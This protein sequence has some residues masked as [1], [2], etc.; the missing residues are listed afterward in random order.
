[1]LY[2]LQQRVVFLF[3]FRFSTSNTHR[4]LLL[5]WPARGLLLGRRTTGR[6]IALVRHITFIKA[7]NNPYCQDNKTKMPLVLCWYA[8]CNPLRD[9]GSSCCKYKT[10]SLQVYSSWSSLLFSSRLS[11]WVRKNSRSPCVHP[12]TSTKQKKFA[13]FSTLCS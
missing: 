12:V 11:V 8:S 9:E 5:C 6:V 4:F 2:G 10:R 13:S 7:K 3:L 1:M